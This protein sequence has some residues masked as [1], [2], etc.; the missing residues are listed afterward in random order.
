M[1]AITI[2]SDFGAP[3]NKVWHCFH[4]FPIYLPWSDGTRCHDLSF[5]NREMQKS[6]FIKIISLVCTSP[7]WG[8]RSCTLRDSLGFTIRSGWN[9]CSLMTDK[10]HVF[11]FLGVHGFTL[12]GCDCW[13]HSS[14]LPLLVMNEHYLGNISWST[15]VPHD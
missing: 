6:G 12:K 2:C 13:F 15:F 11:T 3:Q 5:L 9:C 4:C 8:L 10:W 14:S 1:A 7:I